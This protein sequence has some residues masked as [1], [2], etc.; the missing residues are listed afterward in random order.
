MKILSVFIFLSIFALVYGQAKAQSIYRDSIIIIEAKNPFWEK[1]IAATDSFKTI[2]KKPKKIVSMNFKD[3]DLPNSESIFTKYWH[4]ASITAGK[5]STCWAF[6]ATSYFESEIYRTKNIK[7]KL[8]EMWSAYWEY[9]EKARG[10][11]QSRGKSLFLGGSKAK[12]VSRIWQKYGVVPANVY[13]GLLPNQKYL[14][15]TQMYDKMRD[16]LNFVKEHNIWN[17]EEIIATIKSIMDHWIGT[18]PE[19]FQFEKKYI[20]PKQYLEEYLKLNLDDYVEII[21]HM[22]DPYYEDVE[23]K[24]PA[25]NWRHS[26]DYFNIPLDDFM[27]IIKKGIRDGYTVC[28]AGD[29]LEAGKNSELDVFVVPTFDIPSEYIDENARQFRFSNGST[30][31]DHVVHLV[32]FLEKDGQ[33]WYL[34]KY[35]GASSRNGKLNGYYMYSEDYVKLKMLSYIIHKDLIRDLMIE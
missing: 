17:E 15:T 11:V 26:K 21:S 9:V 22:Q 28:I 12:S 16:Y 32:G 33:D 8:S 2:T 19:T 20:T 27:A 10:F 24:V 29:V 14:C 25:N 23:H 30:T 18:P 5:T 1:I 31:E 4:N 3:Y 35:S 34:I 6:S 7:V 13:T